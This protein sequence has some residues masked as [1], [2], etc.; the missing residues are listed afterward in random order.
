MRSIRS[1]R[2]STT[3]TNPHLSLFSPKSSVCPSL[4]IVERHARAPRACVASGGRV[5]VDSA[6]RWSRVA[7][8]APVM[9][10]S[11][12]VSP[13]TDVGGVEGVAGT[14]IVYAAEIEVRV[15]VPLPARARAAIE[16][17]MVDSFDVM[18]DRFIRY[19][20]DKLGGGP[21][22]PVRGAAGGDSDDSA[23]PSIDQGVGGDA[24]GAAAAA[25]APSSSSVPPFALAT[26]P[27]G[28]TIDTGRGGGLRR[29]SV[30]A[31][32]L[33]PTPGTARRRVSVDL[34]HGATLV[35]GD[36]FY[37]AREE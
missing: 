15:P 33:P 16:D 8:P 9:T 7:P 2:E 35:E 12:D 20:A 36:V 5:V 28:L 22:V 32:S 37:D 27:R 21:P 18:C 26:P 24:A 17:S 30:D 13:V 23:R 34:K 11:F 19:A 14:R 25:A 1:R 10:Y 31:A 3:T 4:T 6:V 29:A